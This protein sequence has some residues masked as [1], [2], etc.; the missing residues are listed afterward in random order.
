MTRSVISISLTRNNKHLLATCSD[1]LIR[2]YNVKTGLVERE[3]SCPFPIRWSQ[4]HPFNPDLALVCT[5]KP[6]TFLINLAQDNSG[7]EFRIT[8]YD[9]PTRQRNKQSSPGSDDTTQAGSSSSSTSAQDAAMTHS[10]SLQATWVPPTSWSLIQITRPLSPK[11]PVASIAEVAR[12]LKAREA[13]SSSLWTDSA[14]THPYAGAKREDQVVFAMFTNDGTRIFAGTSKSIIVVYDTETLEEMYRF[15]MGGGTHYIRHMCFS[16]DDKSF[17]AVSSAQTA[18]L[19]PTQPLHDTRAKAAEQWLAADESERADPSTVALGM[20]YPFPLYAELSDR[21]N[22]MAWRR[23]MFTRSGE[24][25]ITITMDETVQTLYVWSH[26]GRLVAVVRGPQG[27][28]YDFAVHPA[29][30]LVYSITD[31]GMLFV[32]TRAQR[33]KWSAFSP[34]FEELHDNVEYFER[35]DEFDLKVWSTN[36]VRGADIPDEQDQ[37]LPVD[38]DTAHSSAISTLTLADVEFGDDDYGVPDEYDATDAKAEDTWFGN[39]AEVKKLYEKNPPQHQPTVGQSRLLAAERIN[40][41]IRF[42]FP[43]P[44]LKPEVDPEI[45]LAHERGLQLLRIRNA[46]V[47]LNRLAKQSGT[48]VTQFVTSLVQNQLR[49]ETVDGTKP[50][51]LDVIEAALSQAAKRTRASTGTSNSSDSN[52][53]DL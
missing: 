22:R 35:E 25:I 12:I 28:T 8:A 6:N 49:T 23:A 37:S 24:Y 51:N 40:P 50:Q 29:R 2:R 39:G 16:P 19:Y 18:K 44:F 26:Q 20:L 13:V 21:V 52:T 42:R 7:S 41:A 53:S 4:I 9:V 1:G 14:A 3:T 34:D 38:V 43:L 17:V 15:S 27:G 31:T 36:M 10:M 30:P 5:T 32:W 46:V 33:E 11:S 48:S 47:E 45:I